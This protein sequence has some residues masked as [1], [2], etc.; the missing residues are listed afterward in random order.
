MLSCVDSKRRDTDDHQR[1][2]DSL[3]SLLFTDNAV[4]TLLGLPDDQAIQKA[5]TRML[6]EHDAYNRFADISYAEYFM[7]F[8]EEI[9]KS[10]GQRSPSGKGK[11]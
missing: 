8:D 7:A 6:S 5:A 9:D 1:T 3:G 10:T 2:E 4:A 11:A